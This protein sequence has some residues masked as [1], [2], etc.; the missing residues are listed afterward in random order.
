MSTGYPFSSLQGN[1]VLDQIL[2]PKIVGTPVS[3]YQVKLDLGN[4]NTVYATQLGS[5]TNPI[6]DLYGITLR[7]QYLDPPISGGGGSGTTGPTGPTGPGG[8][9][10]VGPTGPKG[11]TGSTIQVTVNEEVEDLDPGI[12]PYVYD[13]G[14]QAPNVNLSFGIPR[15]PTGPPGPPGNSS[16]IIQGPRGNVL[17]YDGTTAGV[18]SNNQFNFSSSALTVPT[19]IVYNSTNDGELRLTTA[20]NVSYIQS[21]LNSNVSQGNTISV[22]R[23]FS[24]TDR[25][26][27]QANTQSYQVA[28]GKANAISTNPDEV[29][30]VYGK[31]VIHVDS[32]A[33]SSGGRYVPDINVT[34]PSSIGTL[35]LAGSYRIYAWGEGGTGPNALAGGE[36]EIDVNVFG[37]GQQLTY[38]ITGA[39]QT[40]GTI[41]Y[42]GGNGLYVTLGGSTVWAYGG[43]GGSSIVS[44]GAGGQAG[45]TI[46]GTGGTID[47]GSGGT[48]GLF[49]FPAGG[50]VLNFNDPY[51]TGTLAYTFPA[52]TTF[53]FQDLITVQNDFVS[54]QMDPGERVQIQLP[55][56]S[57]ASISSGTATLRGTTQSSGQVYSISSLNNI[58]V[59]IPAGATGI[60]GIA[61]SGDGKGATSGPNINVTG[62][63]IQ[64][65]S[66]TDP[67]LTTTTATLSGAS[68]AVFGSTGGTLN[69]GSTAAN[70]F[71]GNTI[72]LTAPM[73]VSFVRGSLTADIVSA[74]ISQNITIGFPNYG[75]ISTAGSGTSQR[76]GTALNGGG[77]GGGY[78]GGGGGNQ[79]IGGAGSSFLVQ[80]LNIVSGVNNSPF[81]GTV[82]YKNQWS[83]TYGSPRLSGGWIVIESRVNNPVALG[84]TGA[85]QIT[86]NLS[87]LNNSSLTCGQI[88]TTG[89]TSSGNVV[90]TGTSTLTAGG[91]IQGADI[92]ATSDRRLKDNIVTI[93]SALDKVMMLRGVYFTRKETDKRNIGVI[94]QETEEI[95]PEVVHTDSDG[96][97]SVAYGNIVGLLIEAIKELNKKPRN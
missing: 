29:L 91:N 46:G 51:L 47:T 71:S 48:G 62:S 90:L 9:G 93:D 15:G 73:L 58:P 25:S 95:I 6:S 33:N 81:P 42:V 26:T 78:F 53:I 40:G 92:I 23:L 77:G 49:Q 66:L 5:S 63:A 2:S 87:I 75:A 64:L 31:T 72:V 55:S 79:N 44:G 76:G 4:L 50:T 54:I 17:F 36:I 18:T 65:L 67:F 88:S 82:P 69:F 89:I 3:G 83:T 39:G 1:N 35:L 14:S 24:G 38:G 10:P 80:S 94:A 20:G 61:L 37:S 16:Q 86:G 13:D 7:Y 30:D 12:P 97:K 74:P 32:G 27:L 8:T 21:G 57:T 52:G 70:E 41:G 34:T 96:M 43:G 22:G 56:A 85:V 45:T 11:S 59:V 19:E 60:T 28:I 84:V 68:S